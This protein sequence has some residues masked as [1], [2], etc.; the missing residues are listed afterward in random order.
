MDGNGRWAQTR[1][2][3]RLLGHRRGAKA[4]EDA[5]GYAE[6]AGVKYLSV[7]AFSTEN[8]RRSEAEVSGLMLLFER[9]IK[10][11][12]GPLK[13]R[14]GRM[15]F[16]GRRD[17]LPRSLVR[18][19]E[20]AEESTRNETGIQLILCVDYGGRQELVDAVKKIVTSGMP[21]ESVTEEALSGFM[22]LPDVPEPDLII[23]TSGEK[24]LSNFWLW[25]GTYSE[26]FFTDALWPDFGKEDLDA[27]LAS[28][29]ARQRRRGGR[30]E[31]QL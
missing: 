17:R 21:P 20:E 19:I 1:G 7:Y 31:G 22:Y 18:T 25:T 10:K 13:A 28:Y 14:H 27:A 8:W 30:P 5:V 29:A 16:A 2:L 26:L 12:L 6:A 9:Y 4:L 23:R 11:K 24:R 15:R 3:P